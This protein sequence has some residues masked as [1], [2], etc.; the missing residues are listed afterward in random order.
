MGT[1]V[2]SSGVASEMLKVSLGYGLLEGS[3]ILYLA[4]GFGTNNIPGQFSLE[5][6]RSSF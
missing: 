6:S 2:G 5:A 3:V 1:L 4:R